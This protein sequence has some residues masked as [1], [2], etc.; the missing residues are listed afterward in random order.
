MPPGSSSKEKVTATSCMPTTCTSVS[1]AALY[2]MYYPTDATKDLPAL[3]G[4]FMHD[5]DM[6]TMPLNGASL[7]DVFGLALLVQSK[8]QHDRRKFRTRAAA[9]VET[10]WRSI[11]RFDTDR[12]KPALPP[13]TN[14]RD[15]PTVYSM[16]KALE[17]HQERVLG[18]VELG[19]VRRYTRAWLYF[20]AHHRAMSRLVPVKSLYLPA[21]HKTRATPLKE[22]PCALSLATTKHRFSSMNSIHSCLSTA[23]SI[24]NENSAH[25]D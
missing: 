15:V 21:T 12:R 24:V 8:H 14:L 18:D 1:L 10:A 6:F 16:S 7:E 25:Y 2:E 22:L 19:R 4:Y 23:W 20:E 3:T 13:H 5:G 9:D 11:S 17:L